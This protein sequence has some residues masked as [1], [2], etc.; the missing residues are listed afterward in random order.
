MFSFFNLYSAPIIVLLLGI[1]LVTVL[2]RRKASKRA[3]LLGAVVM[4][5]C[6]AAW[7]VLR[8]VAR[9]SPPDVAGRPRLLE[10]Q[11]PYCLGCVAVKPGVDR[12]EN[13]LR[14]R[15]VVQR[16]N[17]QTTEGRRLASHHAIKRTPTF[18]LFDAAG[19]ELWRASG[20]LDVDQVRSIVDGLR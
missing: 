20:R 7:F 4:G 15:L 3:W 9:S 12:L 8:P 17:I 19:E 16:V 10:L 6:V 5:G 14:D 11:S 1:C 2:R 13:E 18:V